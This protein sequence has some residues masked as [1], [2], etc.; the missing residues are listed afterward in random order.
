[1]HLNCHPTEV[2]LPWC[3][4]SLLAWASRTRRVRVA[5]FTPYT[6]RTLL[7]HTTSD[8]FLAC[9]TCLLSIVFLFFFLHPLESLLAL[10][11][12][13]GLRLLSRGKT[14]CRLDA[15]ST[16]A[17]TKQTLLLY[18]FSRFRDTRH[19]RRVDSRTKKGESTVSIAEYRDPKVSRI[20]S[21]QSGDIFQTV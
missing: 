20:N 4:S 15:V 13:P 9:D 3:W 12:F 14:E 21:V 8:A 5:Y 18:V 7:H 10:V 6:T 17:R 19:V 16:L 2:S 1:M 11:S